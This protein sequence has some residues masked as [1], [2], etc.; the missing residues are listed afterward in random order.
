[1]VEEVVNS[2]WVVVKLERTDCVVV[3]E[4]AVGGS[5]VSEGVVVVEFAKGGRMLVV[6]V[7]VITVGVV[8]DVEE[9]EELEVLELTMVVVT[10]VDD[11]D[12]AEEDAAVELEAAKVPV[13]RLTR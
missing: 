10:E 6:V 13:T 7:V 8:D 1:M 3:V 9:L 5:V 12:V 2:D 11:V 4:L